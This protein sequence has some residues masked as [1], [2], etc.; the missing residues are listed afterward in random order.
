MAKKSA[1]SFF[2]FACFALAVFLFSS[3][4]VLAFTPDDP[5]FS[6]QRD[7]LN[8]IKAPEAWDRANGQGVVVAVLDSGV[9]INHP[10]LKDNIWVN[11][12]EIPNNGKDD[13]SDGYVDDFNG[14][15]FVDNTNDPRPKFDSGYTQGGIYHGTAIAGIIAA[16]ANNKEGISGVAYG[17]KI[18]PLRVLSADGTGDINKVAKAIRYAVNKGANVINLSLV[19]DSYVQ[20]L[21]DEIKWA[22]S[23]GVVVVGAVGND[24]RNLISSPTYPACYGD[25]LN[26]WI[27]AVA[28]VN[29]SNIKSSFSNC[30][31]G[32]VDLVAPGESLL[33]LNFHDGAVEGFKGYYLKGLTGTSFA[34]ALVSGAAALVKSKN[35]SWQADQ[36]IQALKLNADSVDVYNGDYAGELGAGIINLEKAIGFAASP[37]K[38]YLMKQ[39]KD[40]AVYYVDASGQR[41]LFPNEKIF[42]SWHFGSWSDH[43][44]KIV[45]ST[46]FASYPPSD[47]VRYRPGGLIKFDNSA[48]IYAISN[49]GTLCRLGDDK[50]GEY[51]YGK[52]WLKKIDLIQTAFEADYARNE[53][54]TIFYGGKIPD[55]FV[56][57]YAS[58]SDYWLADSGY[59][60]SLSSYSFSANGFKNDF[61]VD[62]L[63]SSVFY[64]TSR[65]VDDWEVNINPY[66]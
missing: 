54:C 23:K 21:A 53:D 31:A 59:K 32:C 8:Q 7:Y 40:S 46:D 39:E 24:N 63:D 18:M 26:N 20:K 25:N 41:H 58:S 29:G 66:K 11:V 42:W 37:S 9:D 3:C 52:N 19:G 35:Q 27:L 62:G 28:S 47:N 49:N 50:A 61:V 5:L 51:L 10:D 30:G 33:S 60:R 16:K 34:S 15:D 17:A 14:W 57:R 1:F 55:G 4:A 64:E 56:F 13:D 2:I 12:G 48:K 36:I 45:S 22:K 6:Y 65:P 43:Q 38:G 44:V